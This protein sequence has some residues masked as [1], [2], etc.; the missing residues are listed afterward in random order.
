GPCRA[1]G[2]PRSRRVA[3]RGRRD[4]AGGSGDRRRRLDR[5]GSHSSARGA[6][7]RGRRERSHDV[8]GRGSPARGRFADRELSPRAPGG[9]GRSDGGSEVRMI[10]D[11]RYALRGLLRSPGFATAALLTLA[12]GMGASTAVFTL[13]KRVVLDGLPYP[14]SGRLVR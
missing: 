7:V 9:A 3:G 4:P 1:G 6:A 13:L 5:P 14:E 10:Q 2:E 12:L 8:R 11:L